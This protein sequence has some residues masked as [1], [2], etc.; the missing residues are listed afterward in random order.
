MPASPTEGQ[1]AGRS[2]A[3]PAERRTRKVTAERST[4]TARGSRQ[5][6]TELLVEMTAV[7]FRLEAAP[8]DHA[9]ATDGDRA[10]LV[11]VLHAIDD[12]L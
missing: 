7:P 10:D 6:P 12:F 11:V 8:A 9:F 1:L 5:K 4:V 3:S 2:H